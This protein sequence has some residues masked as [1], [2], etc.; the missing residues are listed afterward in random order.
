MRQVER[1]F[2]TSR[3]RTGYVT[4][5]V[6]GHDYSRSVLNRAV[7]S[8]RQPA[9]AFKP[10]YYSL[11]LDDGYGYDTV[12]Y[13]QKVTIKDPVTG[14]EWEPKNIFEDLD[15]DVSLEYAL[16]HS[17]NIP[18]VDLFKRLGADRVVKWT[19]EHLGYTTKMYA[20]D[21]LALGSSCTYLD[22]LARAFAIFARNGK[23]LDWAFVRRILDRDGNVVEDNTVTFDPR[24]RAGDRLD[25]MEATAGIKPRQAISP[26]TAFLTTKLLVKMVENGLTKTIRQTEIKAAGKTGTSSYTLDTQFIGTTSRF[27]SLMWMGDDQ[28]RRA[29]GR[30]DAAYITVVPLWARYMWE[31]A[32]EYPNEDMPYQIPEGVKPDDRGDHSKGQR[33]PRLDLRR[34]YAHDVLEAEGLLPPPE[35]ATPPGT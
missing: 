18:S 3:Y 10:M 29:L 1:F 5:M 11:A 23:W 8:C 24:L 12:L 15:G 26:R 33:G 13:D 21:A 19:H 31:V 20:D 4:A 32:R 34:H 9:S 27:V 14:A 30:S 7:Q 6:G 17:K 25:R 16:V 35:G 22:E 28:N 2:V